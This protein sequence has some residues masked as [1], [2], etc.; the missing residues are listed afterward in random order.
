MSISWKGMLH[1]GTKH[2]KSDYLGYGAG[3]CHVNCTRFKNQK[4]L[5]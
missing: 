3:I 5:H 1:M 4:R 2:V